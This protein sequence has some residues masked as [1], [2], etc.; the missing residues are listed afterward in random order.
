MAAGMTHER[1][2]VAMFMSCVGTKDATLQ[3]TH[4][5]HA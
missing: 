1:G 2:A 4:E 5:L 3:L